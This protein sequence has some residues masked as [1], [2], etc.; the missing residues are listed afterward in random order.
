MKTKNIALTYILFSF[1]DAF[2]TSL[3]PASEINPLGK[4]ILS[5]PVEYAFLS[6]FAFSTLS[7]LSFYYSMILLEREDTLPDFNWKENGEKFVMTLAGIKLGLTLMNI[8]YIM[9]L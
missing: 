8:Y 1:T 5:L 4:A 3:S 7:G 2:A 9:I 6:M